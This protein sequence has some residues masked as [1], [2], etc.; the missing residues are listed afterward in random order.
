MKSPWVHNGE[1]GDAVGALFIETVRPCSLFSDHFAIRLT[2]PRFPMW[3]HNI[4]FISP[5]IQP[6]LRISLLY[7][8][9]LR[10]LHITIRPA[11]LP[12]NSRTRGTSH[13]SSSNLCN[14]YSNTHFY[15]T[16]SS[17]RPL[18]PMV[19]RF[20]HDLLSRMPAPPPLLATP[21]HQFSHTQTGDA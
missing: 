19:T 5:I 6:L 1:G 11:P 4:C 16:L 15:C 21:T 14:I 8:R 20:F 18:I 17:R 3:C 10:L 13:P 7:P 2:H 12:S 9:Y